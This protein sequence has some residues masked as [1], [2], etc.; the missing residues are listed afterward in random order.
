MKEIKRVNG[1]I[2]R[3]ELLEMGRL[4]NYYDMLQEKLDLLNDVIYS[5]HDK[6]QEESFN[7]YSNG[8]SF[9]IMF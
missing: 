3:K 2:L 5:H 6:T 1:Q 7:P 9:F 8:S 4:N